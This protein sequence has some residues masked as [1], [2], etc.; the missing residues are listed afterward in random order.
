MVTF[1]LQGN[2]RI[3]EIGRQLCMA[4]SAKAGRKFFF[5]TLARLLQEHFHFDRLC[6]NLY[7]QQGEM[8][9][10]FTAAEGTVVSTLS[11]VRPAKS[12]S[13]VAG[14]VI[15]TRK[16][17]II[18]DFEK[19]FSGSFVHPIA[20]AGL[21]ATM[22]FPLMLD[23]EIIATLHCSFAEKPVNFYEITSFLLELCPM[24]AVCLGAILSLEQANFQH[25]HMQ[26]PPLSSP[27]SEGPVICHSRAMRDVM[28]RADVA[29][30]L[31]IP[32]L[33]L[34]ETGT[35]KNL[36]A[37]EIHRRSQRKDAPFVRVNCPSLAQTLFESELFGHAKGAFTGAAAKRVGRF[38]LANGGTLFLDE[39]VELSPE[40]QSKLLQVI[41]DSS[42]ERVGESVP[43]AVD[44]RIV[45][46]TNARVGAMLA[47]GKL[48]A[49]LFYR[50]SPC[51][52]ELPP[53]RERCEDI[54]PL[55]A[56]LS[57]RLTASLGLPSVRFTPALIQPML[58]HN[59]PGNVR[60]LRNILSH[61]L[62]HHSMCKQLN[63]SLVRDMIEA[64]GN[65]LRRDKGA[66]KRQ[67]LPPEEEATAGFPGSSRPPAGR[68]V[69]PPQGCTRTL[70][71]VERSHILE[72]LEQTGGTIAGP[73]GAA[74]LLG[75]PR[76]T[77]Q[78]RMRRLGISAEGASPPR[79]PSGG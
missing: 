63:P 52:I 29:A 76:S 25:L 7:D 2:R 67:G 50:L 36:L 49:D 47:E 60:E 78:H 45:A 54:P 48:R 19:H 66:E 17:V 71:E 39:I 10:Y 62:I 18:T 74:A 37:Q 27:T 59:W 43:L 58:D 22:A 15:A 6:I 12:A 56:A 57:S 69:P 53:L 5:S 30:K 1:A 26:S 65:L 35:G 75:I 8:L 46:A 21:T 42:F 20:E 33:L 16:P 23:S 73:A 79:I 77:L 34:G 4:L 70:A 14:H 3:D 24:I 13:T 51:T 61:I 55:I 64:G 68:G 9:T 38:E 31:N 41:E 32:V 11:P 28:R 40:M 72:I 44:V